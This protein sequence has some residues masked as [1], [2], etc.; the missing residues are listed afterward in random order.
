MWPAF[1]FCFC[2]VFCLTVPALLWTG[3]HVC[4]MEM[5]HL[6]EL[7]FLESGDP[8]GDGNGPGL[9]SLHSPSLHSIKR[10]LSPTGP[11]SEWV[12]ATAEVRSCCRN[13]WGWFV[14]DMTEG[15]C[16]LGEWES[17]RTP[18]KG[19]LCAD[20]G[21]RHRLGGGMLEESIFFR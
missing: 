13:V 4:Q 7:P 18:N 14:A 17:G 2:G 5:I 21:R 1:S 11:G 3:F 10:L 8:A 20:S 16:W 9:K 15:P 12:R 19:Y 6:V